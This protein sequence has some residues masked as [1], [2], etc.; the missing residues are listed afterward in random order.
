MLTD[1]KVINI[2]EDYLEED[3]AVETVRTR[4]GMTYMLWD[5]TAKDWSEAVCCNTPEELFD[6]LLDSFRSY[7]ECLILQENG[8]GGMT[9]DMEACI[10]AM[11]RP[12]LEKKKE[13]EK[14]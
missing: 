4:H 13:A 2:F 12:Y 3:Q 14:T 8:W 5:D 9:K 7:Q 6:K 10:Q 11:C 1:E